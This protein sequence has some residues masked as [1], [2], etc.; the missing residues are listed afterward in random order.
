MIPK[1]FLVIPPYGVVADEAMKASRNLLRGQHN[2]V[3]TKDDKTF[4]DNEYMPFTFDMDGYEI[5]RKKFKDEYTGNE[6][7]KTYN[8]IFS[9]IDLSRYAKIQ[10]PWFYNISSWDGYSNF[11]GSKHNLLCSRPPYMISKKWYGLVKDK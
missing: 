7:R 10:M 2:I 1:R 6:T 4:L 5:C 8:D 11:I 9:Q 3:Y